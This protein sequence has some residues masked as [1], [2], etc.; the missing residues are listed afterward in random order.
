MVFTLGGGNIQV[1]D[2]LA[3]EPGPAVSIDIMK[4]PKK[5]L[6]EE[7]KKRKKNKQ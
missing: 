6:P 1:Q 7:A 4:G 3:M 2:K 5:T